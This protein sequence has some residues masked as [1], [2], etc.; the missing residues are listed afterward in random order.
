MKTYVISLTRSTDRRI[1]FDKQN[2]TYMGAYSY[3]DAIDGNTIDISQLK[4]ATFTKGSV[5]YSKGA[6]GCALS[7][8]NLWKKCIEINKPILIMEDDVI[9]SA[10]FTTHLDTVMRMLPV[11]WDILQLSYNFDTVLSF[12]N[13]SYEVCNGI[14][15]QTKMRETDIE[16][17]VHSKIYPTIAK[18]N[19]SFGTS[20]YIIS[21]K[22]ARLLKD[23][24]FPL[25]NTVINVPFIN[26]LVCY[27]IDCMMNTVYK[28]INAYVCVIP[29]VMTPHIS[30]DYKSTIS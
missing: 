22:G 26:K 10:D 19:H 21:P 14:F 16:G 1:H 17:F 11:D 8:L 27:T 12:H 7:H 25:N 6:I 23:K 28:D 30:D 2:S 13:T 9:V 20:A 3:Y 18:L 29:F 5:N 4:P 15:G 24:C